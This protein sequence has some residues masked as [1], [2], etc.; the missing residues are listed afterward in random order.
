[1]IPDATFDPV[2][3][4]ARTVRLRFSLLA[5]FVFVTLVCLLLAWWVQPNRVVATALF[6]VS[7]RQ[8]TI[9]G[10]ESARPNDEQEFEIVK[11]TQLASIKSYYVLIAAVRKPGIASLPILQG[12]AE[13]T[14][15][16][17]RHLE[18]GYPE[19]SEILEISLRGPEAYATD[20]VRI[21]DAVADAYSDEVVFKERSREL[22]S[23]DIFARSLDN[24]KK[25]IADK[26]EVYLAIARE[27]DA[28]ED[29]A[30]RQLNIN[31]LDRVEAEL[32]RLESEQAQ[33]ETSAEPESSK[34]YEKRIAQLRERQ[35][36]LE[37]KLIPVSGN[38]VELKPRQAELDQLQRMAN[39]MTTK[40][41]RMEIEA[42]APQRIERLQRAVVSPDD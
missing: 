22:S 1:M 40:L 15:W 30:L 33:Q 23:R 8:P 37:K 6:R 11:K 25:T 21:V 31:R 13:P 42:N 4:G 35:A 34:F 5:L 20:L 24:L 14:D 16:I 10:D 39:E 29:E 9:L 36:E 38:S 19:D 17:E 12:Q 41:L 28:F 18:V 32:M 7:S 27:S 26:S 2:P 3:D